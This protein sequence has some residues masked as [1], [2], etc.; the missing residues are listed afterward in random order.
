MIALPCLKAQSNFLLGIS[1]EEV[2]SQH[3]KLQDAVEYS[4]GDKWDRADGR[5]NERGG[6][7]TA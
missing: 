4:H 1:G 3:G 5:D 7:S 2:L 6:F